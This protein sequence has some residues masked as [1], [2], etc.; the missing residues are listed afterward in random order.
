M[1]T[2]IVIAWN[3]THTPVIWRKA[4]PP[5]LMRL[6][7][8]PTNR[9]WLQDGRRAKPGWNKAAKQWELPAAWFNDLVDRGLQRWGRIYIIQPYREQEKCAPACRNATGHECQC[10]CMGAHHGSGGGGGWFDV[11]DTFSTRWGG[12]DVACRLLTARP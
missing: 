8:D 12:E 9:A 3:Q 7:Y 10:S 6:P 5:I 11:S 2:P 4:K 1:Q